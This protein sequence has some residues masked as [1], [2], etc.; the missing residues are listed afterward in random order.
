M[1]RLF[2]DRAFAWVMIAPVLIILGAVMIIP[3]IEILR[4]SFVKYDVFAGGMT[5]FVGLENYKNMFSDPRF[6][7]ALWNTIKFT[8]ITV[9]FQL[10]FG[11]G[12]AVVLN[13]KFKGRTVIRVAVLLPWAL[14]TIINSLLFRWMFD[15]KFG[16]FNDILMRLGLVATPVDWLVSG[17][18]ASFAIYVTQIWKMS[19]YMGLIILAG[20]QSIPDNLYESA[21]VDGASGWTQFIRITLPLIRPAVIVAVIF[22][23]VIALQVFD[24][25]YAMTKGGPGLATETMVYSI[26]MQTFRYTEFGYGS[27]LSVFLSLV[28]M[29]FGIL[30]ARGLYRRESAT[31]MGA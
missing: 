3:F 22:R 1:G 15:S 4:M 25:V 11:L 26:Y 10:L 16:L 13:E 24:V 9:T 14:P 28:I 30:Y 17:V 21:R 8:F 18:G 12:I 2:S 23:T 27:T 31:G 19:S 7:N 6:Y 5:S 20:L 29:F